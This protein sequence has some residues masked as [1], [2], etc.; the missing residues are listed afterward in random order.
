MTEEELAAVLA[1]LR[2]RRA[3]GSGGVARASAPGDRF[4][5]PAVEADSFA[6]W[7]HRRL[8]ALNQAPRRLISRP[9]TSA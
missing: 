3:S 7:R 1:A 8:T 2:A 4:A 9:P 5:R 6:G